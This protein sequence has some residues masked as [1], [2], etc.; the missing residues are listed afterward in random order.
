MPIKDRSIN[1]AQEK[2]GGEGWLLNQFKSDASSDHGQ[3]LLVRTY[4]WISPHSI[5]D[6]DGRP[7]DCHG[8]WIAMHW[9]DWRVQAAESRK[10]NISIHILIEFF[11]EKDKSWIQEDYPQTWIA[12]ICT[13]KNL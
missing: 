7:F 9:S 3:W 10:Q 8:E 13:A 1:P 2:A 4:S 6:V 12:L 5:S 11:L